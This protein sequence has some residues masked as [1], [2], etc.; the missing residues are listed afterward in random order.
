M[1][2]IS[3][4]LARLNLDPEIKGDY[5]REAYRLITTCIMKLEKSP[6]ALI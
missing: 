6:I 5:V 3:E 4:A 2:R 1:I